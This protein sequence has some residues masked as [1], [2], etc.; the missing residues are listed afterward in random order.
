[1]N[2]TSIFPELVEPPAVVPTVNATN[3]INTIQLG[4]TPTGMNIHYSTPFALKSIP[5][6]MWGSSNNI[7]ALINNATGSVRTYARTPTCVPGRSMAL[8]N[9]W[10]YDIQIDNLQPSTTYYYYIPA[11]SSGTTASPVL[12]FTTAIAKGAATPYNVSLVC[13]MGYT[14]AMGT[15]QVLLET[16]NSTQFV[17]HGGVCIFSRHIQQ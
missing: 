11:D 9:Q 16:L 12:S 2:G 8:C 14:N 1:M 6:V 10:F 4:Y 15:Y 7:T 5:H 13:D 17:W 3:S